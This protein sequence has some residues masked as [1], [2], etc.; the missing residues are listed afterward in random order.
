[1]ELLLSTPNCIFEFFGA[2]FF[3][4]ILLI[5]SSIIRNYEDYIK[6]IPD[7]KAYYWGIMWNWWLKK[8]LSKNV[9]I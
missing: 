6:I 3:R 1:M 4:N 2:F 5:N 9:E 7:D 8:N